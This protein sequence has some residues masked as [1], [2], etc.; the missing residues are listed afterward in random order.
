[1]TRAYLMGTLSLGIVCVGIALVF[2]VVAYP[3]Q[4]RIP[5]RAIGF[6]V[7]PVAI[8][9]GVLGFRWRHLM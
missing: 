6:S 9:I 8:V 2:L 7:G 1:M 5:L 4:I 3:D